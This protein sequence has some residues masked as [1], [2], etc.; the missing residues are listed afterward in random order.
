MLH[1]GRGGGFIVECHESRSASSNRMSAEHLLGQ[2]ER[3]FFLRKWAAAQAVRR[4]C[5]PRINGAFIP[6]FYICRLRLSTIHCFSIESLDGPWFK[7]I[8]FADPFPQSCL[9]SRV[10]VRFYAF[11]HHFPAF[12][13]SPL[14]ERLRPTGAS[15]ARFVSPIELSFCFV[16]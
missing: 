8:F 5:M 15:S 9:G 3:S 2:E 4:G 13:V 6:G 7:S 14:G 11:L 1:Q 12:G 10:L 16:S